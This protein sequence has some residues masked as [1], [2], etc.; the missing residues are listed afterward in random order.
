[1]KCSVPLECSAE[2]NAA[3]VTASMAA[4]SE[5]ISCRMR[6]ISFPLSNDYRSCVCC[7]AVHVGWRAWL[8]TL[9]DFTAVPGLNHC[10]QKRAIHNFIDDSINALAYTIALLARKLFTPRWA[11][12]FGQH[13]YS[14]QNSCDV[15]LRDASQI[16][17]HRL[18]E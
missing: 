1:M 4:A 12:I 13:V 10:N 18:L 2:R 9:V 5:G 3:I 14:L 17:G 8:A 15:V 11:R 7:A 6:I 16:F